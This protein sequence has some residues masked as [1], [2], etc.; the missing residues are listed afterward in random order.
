MILN[1]FSVLSYPARCGAAPRLA[2]CQGQLLSRVPVSRDGEFKALPQLQ[3]MHRQLRPPLR[4]AQQ[5]RRRRKLLLL[6]HDALHRHHLVSLRHR[7][8]FAQHVLH[9]DFSASILGN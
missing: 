1:F 3:Q 4:L 8:Y 9:V 7:H 6:F 5:L 2:R